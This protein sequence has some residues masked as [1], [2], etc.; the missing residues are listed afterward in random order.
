MSRCAQRNAEGF[1]AATK[2]D[3]RTGGNEALYLPSPDYIR[4]PHLKAFENT[5]HYYATLLHECGHWTGH[6]KRLNRDLNT[7]FKTKAYAAGAGCGYWP[8]ASRCAVLVRGDPTAR[9]S[10]VS[11]AP[12]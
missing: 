5:G 4:M 10:G 11:S 9:S 7:R 8:I 1:I 3:I 2:A 6:E 12:R